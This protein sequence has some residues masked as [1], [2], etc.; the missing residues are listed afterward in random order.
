MAIASRFR[1]FI[2]YIVLQCHDVLHVVERAVP[3]V[4]EVGARLYTRCSR[5]F[6]QVVEVLED[7][8][9][10]DMSRVRTAVVI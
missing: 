10:Q 9:A 3:G 6:A 8:V 2:R 7:D 4:R 1:Q 5:L